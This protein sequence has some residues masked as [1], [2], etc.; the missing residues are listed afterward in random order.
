MNYKGNLYG[1][2]GGTYFETGKTSDDWDKLESQTAKIEAFRE[3]ISVS[4]EYFEENNDT[5]G[6]SIMDNVFDKFNELFPK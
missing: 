6:I 4:V 5:H 1:H 3:W 2:I